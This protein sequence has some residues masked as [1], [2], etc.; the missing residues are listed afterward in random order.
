MPTRQAQTRLGRLLAAKG[1]VGGA[2]FDDVDRLAPG[3]V[4]R[5]QQVAAMLT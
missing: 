3:V 4:V 1:A 2:M 5:D